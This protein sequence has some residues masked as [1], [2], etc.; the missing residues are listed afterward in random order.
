[1]KCSKDQLFKTNLGKLGVYRI[2]NGVTIRISVNRSS[3]N[4]ENHIGGIIV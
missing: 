2:A 3:G 4:E 1:M